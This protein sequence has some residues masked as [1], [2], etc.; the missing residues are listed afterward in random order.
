[1]SIEERSRI[2]SDEGGMKRLFKESQ[3][4]MIKGQRVGL[5][6]ADSSGSLMLRKIEVRR[7]S[8]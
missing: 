1:M 6:V 3:H 2:Y 5:Q 7:R 8:G 4:A